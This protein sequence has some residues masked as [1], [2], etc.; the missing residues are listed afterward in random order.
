MAGLDPALFWL[1]MAITL[2]AGVVKGAVGFAMPMIMISGFSSF[3]TP[4]LALA[5]LIAMLTLAAL[6]VGFVISIISQ[7]DS[8]AIQ[9]SMLLLLLSIFFSGF[10]MPLEN[11]LAPVRVVGYMLPITHGINGLQATLLQGRVPDFFTWAGLT[12]ISALTLLVIV[13]VGRRQFRQA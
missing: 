12:T 11:F 9:L 4:E 2:F 13:V 3:L 10:L 8:Q 5:G 7:S 1:A 6:G